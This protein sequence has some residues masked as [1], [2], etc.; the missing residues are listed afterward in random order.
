MKNNGFTLI[1]M[2]LVLVVI[3]LILGAVSIGKDMQRNAVYLKAN[4]QFIHGW[5]NAYQEYYDRTGIVLGDDEF[6]PTLEVNGK[7]RVTHPIH[8]VSLRREI[9]GSDLHELM[10]SAGIEMPQGRAEGQEDKFVYLDTNG[11]PQE[12][13][14]CFKNIPWAVSASGGYVQRQKNVLYLKNV[15]PDL[16]R[17]IDH[18]VD[19]VTDARFGKVREYYANVDLGSGSKE[20]H[21]DNTYAYGEN[22]SSN[23][24]ESQV[25]VTHL[26]YIMNQ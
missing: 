7:N 15:T 25:V 11:N 16:A 4:S 19:N 24:D 10:D 5:V 13:N 8:G 14:V 17:M 18:S 21:I 3:G 1:E 23:L 9:C 12:L 20:W 26:Y 6:N 2:S 22:T